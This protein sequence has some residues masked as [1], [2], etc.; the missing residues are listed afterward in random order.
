MLVQTRALLQQNENVVMDATFH[1]SSARQW[2]VEEL[3]GNDPFFI[4]VWAEEPVA[5]KRVQQPRPWSEAG[6]DVYAMIKAQWEPMPEPHLLLQSTDNNINEM[7]QLA[8]DW[9]AEP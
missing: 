5:R 1:K 3:A 7:L 6:L 2:F 8:S 9:L 4:E